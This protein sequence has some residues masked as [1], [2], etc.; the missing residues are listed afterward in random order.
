MHS[1][2][3]NKKP[4]IIHFWQVDG[5]AKISDISRMKFKI[6][7]QDYGVNKLA[8]ELNFDK[9]TIYSIYFQGR[10]KGI[11]SIKHLLDIAILLNY[12][13]EVLEKEIIAYGKTQKDIYNFFFPF[14]LSP[15]H[16][17]T[18]SIHGDGSINKL[19]SQCTWYQIHENIFYM[20]KLL[21]LLLKSASIKSYKKDRSISSIT[22]PSLLVYLTCKSLELNPSDFDSINF[23]KNLSELPKEFQFQFFCQFIVDE[24]HFKDKTLTISQK[25]QKTRKGLIMLLDSLGFDH[26]NPKNNKADITIYGYNFSK[27]LNY[28]DEAI[29]KYGFIAGLWFKEDEFRKICKI[30]NEKLSKSIVE[31]TKINKKILKRLKTEKIFLSY[32]D[33][34]A[35]GRTT[36]Q[37][38]KAIRCW[39]KNRQIKRVSWNRYR[40]LKKDI[41]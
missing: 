22:I 33:I 2:N 4:K 5:F 11:H 34:K 23:F 24:G 6:L 39:K 10:K 20:E 38:N 41:K 18:V 19:T 3:S 26:S 1:N 21:K 12:D 36:C 9:E 8:K 16:L 14:L 30:N 28:L 29:I 13:L 7:I 32:N 37:V 17:R 25:K 40:I 35:F 27:I 31:S 15:L